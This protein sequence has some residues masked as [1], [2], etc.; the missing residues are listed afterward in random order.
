MASEYSL[1]L[2]PGADCE[3]ALAAAIAR[4][5]AELGGAHFAPHLTIQGDIGLPLERLT[6]PASK[7]AARISRQRWRVQQVE[8]G[9]HFF[10][11]L[12][13]R[14]AVEP[15]FADMQNTSLAL[16]GT[17]DGLSPFAHLSLAYGP[18]HPDSA[19]LCRIL[20]GEFA[21]KEIA[22]D[23]LA[24]SRSSSTVPIPEWECLAQY[25]LTAT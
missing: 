12:Y 20:S 7:L 15:A 9:T 25:S 21:E 14:F 13:L 19:R 24:I 8:C 5:S 18:P 1:W 11:S 10:R 23:R 3:P 4:L 16:T 22:F 17:R 6:G 2:L